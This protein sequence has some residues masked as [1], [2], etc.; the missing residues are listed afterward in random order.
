MLSL[1]LSI[2]RTGASPS[3][4]S[5]SSVRIDIFPT[6]YLTAIRA[7][8]HLLIILFPFDDLLVDFCITTYDS[9]NVTPTQDYIWPLS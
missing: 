1:S 6:V 5:P 9:K 8:G 3:A 2:L 4:Y 7:S